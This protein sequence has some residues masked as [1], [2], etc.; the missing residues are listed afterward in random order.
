MN[1]DCILIKLEEYNL[2]KEP[3]I[4]A[5]KEFKQE[6]NKLNEKHISECNK[7]KEEIKELKERLENPII[8]PM[9]IQVSFGEY[10]KYTKHFFYYPDIVAQNIHLDLPLYN[11]IKRI[12]GI[13]IKRCEKILETRNSDSYK[14]GKNNGFIEVANMSFFERKKFL[15]QYKSCK[16]NL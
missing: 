13:V 1:K 15:K 12:A 16:N 4:K 9:K 8:D 11:Q 3:Y 7:L 5:Q 6:L 2:L 10:S 14:I